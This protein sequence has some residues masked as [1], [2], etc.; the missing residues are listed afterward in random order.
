MIPTANAEI[1]T[2]VPESR[3]SLSRA[4]FTRREPR[5][6]SAKTVSITAVPPIIAAQLSPITVTSSGSAGF[7]ATAKAVSI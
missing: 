3:A 6:G 5:P 1:R 4:A 7:T 2:I